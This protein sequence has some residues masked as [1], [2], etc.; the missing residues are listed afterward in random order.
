MGVQ[1]LDA[2]SV[3]RGYQSRI[4]APG[5]GRRLR[6]SRG[7]RT[8]FGYIRCHQRIVEQRIYDLVDLQRP[9]AFLAQHA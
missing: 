9:A 3:E 8:I 4:N 2:S 5:K 1:V 7:Q 6:V